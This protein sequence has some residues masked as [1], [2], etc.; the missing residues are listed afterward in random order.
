[1]LKEIKNILLYNSGGGL[2]DSLLMI[3]LMQWLKDY[4]KVTKI[5]YIQNGEYKYFDNSLKDFKE[6]NIDT[7]DFLPENFAFFR[8][9]QIKTYS[10]FKLSKKILDKI[11]IKQFDLII[12]TQT[13]I[14]NSLVMRSIP[15]KYY[16]SPCARFI[17]SNPRK[18]ILSSRHVSGR[19]FDYFEK[20]LKMNIA[21][22]TELKN[23][24]NKYIEESTNLF[25]KNKKYIGFSITAGHPTRKKEIPISTVIEV[26]NY[27]A[28]KNFVPTFLVEEKYDTLIKKIKSEV[29]NSFFPEHQAK[30]YLKNPLLVIAISK[31][32]EL[33]ISID[34]GILQM[35]SLAGTKTAVFFN[36][37]QNSEKFKPLNLNK[38]KIFSAS[39]NKR[40]EDLTSTEIINFISDFF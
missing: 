17:L 37:N 13:R 38:T 32:L 22:P 4:Y 24:D 30:S 28:N 11:G 15:H 7:L 2:G 10:F 18:L 40:L 21:I 16:I 5:Y 14:A 31:K 29:K 1:M 27:F 26:A 39:Q 35:L 6:P 34:N 20:V 9:N 33:A 25:D 3:P 8:L 19:I 36:E 23:L 12:D